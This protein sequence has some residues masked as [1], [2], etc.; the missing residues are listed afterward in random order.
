MARVTDALGN[1]F[2]RIPK[3]Y[4][5]KTDGTNSKTWQVSKVQHAGYYLPWCF[6]DFDNGAELPYVDVGAYLGS[7]D[8]GNR[9]ESKSGLFPQL[10]ASRP[11]FRTY[12]KANNSGGQY[13]GYQQFDVHV[14]DVIRTLFYIEF[15][16][17]NT[18]GVLPGLIN[19]SYAAG[20]LVTANTTAASV[21]VATAT[22]DTFKVGQYIN[23][24]TTLGMGQRASNRK[25]TGIGAESGG[26]KVI[27][28]DGA[29]VTLQTN[30][31]VTVAVP[32]NGD[33]SITATSGS[34]GS[35]G[36]GKSPCLYRGIESPWGSAWCVVDGVNMNSGQAWVC[37]NP[38]S[39]AESTFASPYEQLG[40]VNATAAGWQVSRGYDSNFPFAEFPTV[41]TG[42][43][44]STYYMDYA[45]YAAGDRIMAH[46][47]AVA[48]GALAGVSCHLGSY[49]PADLSVLMTSRL[50]KKPITSQRPALTNSVKLAL[51]NGMNS[52]VF[53]P[54]AGAFGVVVKPPIAGWGIL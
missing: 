43:S 45:Y 28:F 38:A 49:A 4:I 52:M 7:K 14:L 44:S 20:N 27:S 26:N 50:V 10:S 51:A 31:I 32:K 8:A 35:N 40:Y 39:Y 41:T 12:A 17:L 29:A 25:I 42:G 3:F 22:A 6:W 23:I 13:M 34:N 2:V 15:A 19:G 54:T 47:G 16:T 5:R 37:K 48:D 1:V 21:T 24:G 36:D 30:D 9:M 46:G 53:A 33:V 18:A 11:T